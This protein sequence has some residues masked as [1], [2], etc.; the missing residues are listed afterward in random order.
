MDA[1]VPS[2]APLAAEGSVVLEGTHLYVSGSAK[3]C[4]EW[5]DN[6]L[7]VLYDD[8]VAAQ[9]VLRDVAS[10]G[11]K[12]AVRIRAAPDVRRV[13]WNATE[14]ER[15]ALAART[16]AETRDAEH[17]PRARC[18]VLGRRHVGNV[19]VNGA[20]RLVLRGS[21]V[22]HPKTL[23]V[24]VGG[25]GTVR[26]DGVRFAPR[27]RLSVTGAGRIAL[28]ARCQ[29]GRLRVIA[30]GTSRVVVK[31]PLERLVERTV[32]PTAS[33][34]L[35]GNPPVEPSS[36]GAGS[37]ATRKRSRPPSA[38]TRPKPPPKKRLKQ[39]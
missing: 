20:A 25:T 13:L 5:S 19:H 34:E 2:V 8:R 33:C 22:Q 27:L 3:L 18:F 1:P 28:D 24:K 9:L 17:V 14:R 36:R 7:R 29:V 10:V 16:P 35:A 4:V 12:V 6:K 23:E 11:G 37:L 39:S 38:S 26:A 32:A 30:Q 15:Q 31:C 21:V